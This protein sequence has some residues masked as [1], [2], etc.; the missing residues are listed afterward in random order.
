MA[1]TSFNAVDMPGLAVE[2]NAWSADQEH[3]FS[4]LRNETQAGFAEV[5]ARIEQ[6]VSA[7]RNETQAATSPL[8][9]ALLQPNELQEIGNS[10]VR[11]EQG[12]AQQAQTGNLLVAELQDQ[13]NAFRLE[14]AD[15]QAKQIKADEEIRG[16]TG[17]LQAKFIE[18]ETTQQQY[19]QQ[20]K[21]SLQTDL[22][23]LVGKLD[24]LTRKLEARFVTIETRLN[25]LSAEA[26]GGT[27]A[28]Q[29]PLVRWRRRR[30]PADPPTDQLE[31]GCRGHRF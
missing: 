24:E 18:I 31:P 5:I 9:R 30:E 26:P 28:E 23:T 1:F 21:E 20:D 29:D 11:L 14:L 2:L 16:L 8:A 25:A 3:A 27:A 12:Q 22:R 15:R 17:Q 6:S 7:L 13:F 4:E 19:R 10:I